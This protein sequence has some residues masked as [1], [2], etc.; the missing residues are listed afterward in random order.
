[1]AAKSKE[2]RSKLVA[3]YVVKIM[4]EYQK[5]HLWLVTTSALVHPYLGHNAKVYQQVSR[6][7]YIRNFV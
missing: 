3:D 2:D 7:R 6:R 5:E 4:H 1:M